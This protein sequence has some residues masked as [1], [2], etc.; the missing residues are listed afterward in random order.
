MK[1]VE[2][3][4]LWFPPKEGA[5]REAGGGSKGGNG[6]CRFLLTAISAF[7]SNDLRCGCGGAGFLPYYVLL[8]FVGHEVPVRQGGSHQG[9]RGSGLQMGRGLDSEVFLMPV[10]CAPP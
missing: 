6:G 9:E 10:N 4:L 8:H 5:L 7:T 3:G 1:F 2:Q